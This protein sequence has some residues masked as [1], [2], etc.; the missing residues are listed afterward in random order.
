MTG[1]KK[2]SMRGNA[3]R[4]VLDLG[5]DNKLRVSDDARRNLKEVE[6]AKADMAGRARRKLIG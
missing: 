4:K 3:S 1:L 2:L 6:R 5:T